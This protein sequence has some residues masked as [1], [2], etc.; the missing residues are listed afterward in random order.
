MKEITSVV[1]QDS[2]EKIYNSWAQSTTG[3]L[4]HM[5]FYPLAVIEL[6]EV[7]SQEMRC[8][9]FYIPGGASP[10]P[11]M[12]LFTASIDEDVNTVEVLYNKWAESVDYAVHSTTLFNFNKIEVGEVTTQTICC[13]VFFLPK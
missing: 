5:E 7:V 8:A 13:A 2:I 3:A 4:S 9:V 1:G 6:G 10:L 12:K 11:T